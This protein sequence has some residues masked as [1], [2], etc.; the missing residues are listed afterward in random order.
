MSLVIMQAVG[1][2]ASP[3]AAHTVRILDNDKSGVDGGWWLLE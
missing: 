3:G 2:I 1:A